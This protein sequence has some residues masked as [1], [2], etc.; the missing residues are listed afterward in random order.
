MGGVLGVERHRAVGPEAHDGQVGSGVAGA[1]YYF[2]VDSADD[3]DAGPFTIKPASPLPV[4]DR[5]LVIDENLV[6]ARDARYRMKVAAVLE[7]ILP[8]R[9]AAA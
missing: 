2:Y 8:G 7:S 3:S 1:T 6:T 9:A 5:A 4:V